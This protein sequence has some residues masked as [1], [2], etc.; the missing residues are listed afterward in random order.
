MIIGRPGVHTIRNNSKYLC[1]ACLL[2]ALNSSF[3]VQRHCKGGKGS[4]HQCRNGQRMSSEAKG[5]AWLM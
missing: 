3:D 1:K 4:E 2:Q 5:F